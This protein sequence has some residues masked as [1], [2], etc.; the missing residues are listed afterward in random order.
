M[1]TCYYALVSLGLCDCQ[2]LCSEKISDYILS[3]IRPN[4]GFADNPDDTRTNIFNTY[5]GIVS[6]NMLEQLDVI[7]SDR[8]VTFLLGK[9]RAG[10]G[11][12]EREHDPPSLLHTFWT[13]VSLDLLGMA[14]TLRKD[15]IKEFLDRCWTPMGLWANYE[16][17]AS[18]YLEYTGYAIVLDNI[19]HLN[20]AFDKEALQAAI[21]SRR[22]SNGYSSYS[23]IKPRV[24][25]T[26]WALYLLEALGKRHN[27]RFDAINS[28]SGLWRLFLSLI[29]RLL[30]TP[31][32]VQPN[33]YSIHEMYMSENHVL[34][35][36]TTKLE[37]SRRDISQLEFLGFQLYKAVPL[38]TKQSLK[39]GKGSG[40]MLRVKS[41]G[42]AL[43]WESTLCD[44]CLLQLNRPTSRLNKCGTSIQYLDL[45]RCLIVFD[46]SLSSCVSE[47]QAIVDLFSTYDDV[48]VVTRTTNT[49]S[50][51]EID[52]GYNLIHVTTHGEDGTINTEEGAFSIAAFIRR[53]SLRGFDGILVLN[54]CVE[55]EEVLRACQEV[56]YA[57]VLYWGL[58]SGSISKEF[59]CELYRCLVNSITLGE[60]VRLAKLKLHQFAARGECRHL[61]YQLWGNPN[62]VCRF[63][64]LPRFVSPADTRVEP[65]GKV[66]ALAQEG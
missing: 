49:F 50:V 30:D 40:A 62:T 60:A 23:L 27:C 20:V 47:R 64:R 41:P 22:A 1:E 29:L 25:D 2:G 39:M 36:L 17:S 10:G 14:D 26:F 13:V 15:S 3:H 51:G 28:G 32:N 63:S 12:S 31:S 9:R 48:D 34:K 18:G 43:P 53:L 24:S 33:S 16:G 21:E 59:S 45:S 56:P 11:F 66:D 5:F 6:L 4:G 65:E 61:F 38:S 8:T 42:I 52:K 19:L 54:V 7:H 57:I 37:A 35:G 46:S 55:Q 44:G 58:L